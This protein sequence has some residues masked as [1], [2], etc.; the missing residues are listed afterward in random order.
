MD[1]LAQRGED[2]FMVED[3][4]KFYIVNSGMKERWQ[5]IHPQVLYKAGYCVDPH[6]TQEQLEAIRY[7]ME[8]KEPVFTPEE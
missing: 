8:N 1:I 6:P 5:V 7:T 4:G 2:I 3:G